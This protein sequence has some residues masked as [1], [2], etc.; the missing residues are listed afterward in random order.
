MRAIRIPLSLILASSL[1]LVVIVV[2]SLALSRYKNTPSPEERAPPEWPVASRLRHAGQLPTLLLFAHPRCSCTQATVGELERLMARSQGLVSTH[3]VFY[4][5]VGSTPDWARGKLWDA[6]AAIPGVRVQDDEG[7]RE[8]L[9]FHAGTSGHAVLYDPSG[10][11]SFD[12]GIT[13]ARGHAGDSAGLSAL[14]SLLHHG[15][16]EQ[17]FTSVFGCLLTDPDP[18]PGQRRQ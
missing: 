7:G 5:P 17:P 6:A 13:A 1:W 15:A 9:L 11:L 14:M 4:R 16:A 3:V 12:G 10:R 2:G 8:A 18:K